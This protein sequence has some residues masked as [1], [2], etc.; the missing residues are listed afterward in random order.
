MFPNIPS[1]EDDLELVKKVL[2]KQQGVNREA[3]YTF[4][5]NVFVAFFIAAVLGL[6]IWKNFTVGAVIFGG[7]IVAAVIIQLTKYFENRAADKLATIRILQGLMNEQQEFYFSRIMYLQD[8]LK[9][10]EPATAHVVNN[11]PAPKKTKDKG[12]KVMDIGTAEDV[13]FVQVNQY[14]ERVE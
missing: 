1:F 8:L 6:V 2:L 10:M 4:L 5:T 7:V 13:G 3:K 9:G 11:V 14:G 12:P